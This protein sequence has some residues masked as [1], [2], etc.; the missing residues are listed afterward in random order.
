MILGV[1]VPAKRPRRAVVTLKVALVSWEDRL[2]DTGEADRR[3]AVFELLR[4]AERT[5]AAPPPVAGR[6]TRREVHAYLD[7]LAREA[8][9]A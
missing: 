5:L 2:P 6:P 7:E 3:L 9:P 4:M 1:P 8:R